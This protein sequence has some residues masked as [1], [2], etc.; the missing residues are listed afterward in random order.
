MSTT[1]S[2]PDADPKVATVVSTWPTDIAKFIA[3][4]IANG[5]YASEQALLQDA[6][7]QL[8]DRNLNSLRKELQFGLDEIE[9]GDCHELNNE[10]EVAEFFTDLWDDVKQDLAADRQLKA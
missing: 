9:R 10:T 2:E 8:R 4:E 7:R 6:V 1:Q 5:E 3:S